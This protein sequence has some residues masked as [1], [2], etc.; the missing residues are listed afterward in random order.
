MEKTINFIGNIMTIS[1]HNIKRDICQ[2]FL[3]NI[4]KIFLPADVILCLC[5]DDECWL[6]FW[7][8]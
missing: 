7:K 3:L 6:H 8:Y 2:A 5:C 4:F 1:Y